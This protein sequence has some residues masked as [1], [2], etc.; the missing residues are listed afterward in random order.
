MQQPGDDGLGQFQMASA[1]SPFELLFRSKD[2]FAEQ[3]LG[4]RLERTKVHGFRLANFTAGSSL[5]LVGQRGRQLQLDEAALD[6]ANGFAIDG[7]VT[8]G[9][10]GDVVRG[11]GDVNGDGFDD[12]LLAGV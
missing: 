1:A 5:N 3:S 6:G 9:R 2:R 10:L 7:I 12:L 8:G 11:V 4:L